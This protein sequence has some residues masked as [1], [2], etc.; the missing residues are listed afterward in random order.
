MFTRRSAD[1][2]SGTG[3]EER[4]ILYFRRKLLL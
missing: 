4:E 1:G 2:V 3:V